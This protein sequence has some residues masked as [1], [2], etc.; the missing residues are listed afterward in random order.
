MEKTVARRQD[1][2]QLRAL[3][4]MPLRDLGAAGARAVPECNAPFVVEKT[5]KRYGTVRRCLSEG[6]EYKETVEEAEAV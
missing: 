3:S 1:L 6:C 4:G 5:T 2:L